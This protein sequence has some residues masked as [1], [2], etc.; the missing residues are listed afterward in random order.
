MAIEKSK[1]T[2][3]FRADVVGSMLRPT[4]LL[5]ARE[6]FKRH[7]IS[8]AEFKRIEDEAVDECVVIQEQAGV[9]VITDGEVRRNV[10]ASQLA[11][12]TEGFGTVT[13]NW[14]DW[15][16]VNGK[17]QHDPVTMAL[18]SKIKRK[19]HLSSEEFSYLRGKTKKPIKVTLPSPTMYAYYWLPGV[20]DK[21]YPS[22]KEY[23]AEVASILND[24]VD[25]LVRLGAEYI[26]FDAPEFGM[27]IDAHQ[28]KWFGE[29]GFAA[30][31][32]IEE[33]VEMM[34]AI[35]DEHPGIVFGLHICRGNDKSRYMAKG[36]YSAIARR[37]FEN[38]HAQ[39]LLLEFDDERS[40]DFAPLQFVPKDKIVVL[41][42]VTTKTPREETAE[43][44]ELRIKEASK[45]IP[46]ERLAL[47]T[48]CGFASVAKGNAVGMAIQQK[49]LRLVAD[50]ARKIWG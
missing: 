25:E 10:F 22:T 41:G 32:L 13:D 44:L 34:N 37:V 49:K 28:Q 39:R 50:V 48:Q 24:E 7:E 8:P 47:S 6:K 1:K 42:L 33:G 30:D 35:I 17:V 14:V 20:S 4:V 21:A 38:T 5:D 31:T 27:L 11:Q 12:A 29:K 16:D 43:E 46:L 18:V 23:L 36:S 9:D 26:Q 19:R 3:M 15:F 45:F 40:G 2:H